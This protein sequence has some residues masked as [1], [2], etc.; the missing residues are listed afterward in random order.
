MIRRTRC[1][2]IAIA[3][4][5][6]FCFFTSAAFVAPD[7]ATA[8]TMMPAPA[9][10]QISRER[11]ATLTGFQVE[12]LIGVRAR[13]D[14]AIVVARSGKVLRVTLSN[15]ETKEDR[16]PSPLVDFALG[17]PEPLGLTQTGAVISM[18]TVIG[19]PGWSAGTF[20]SCAIDS[21]G[22]DALLSGGK[23]SFFL[24][25]N[26]SVAMPI[27]SSKFAVLWRDGF[28]WN[29]K[30][31]AGNRVWQADIT[32]VYGNRMKRMYRFSPEF[33]PTGLRVGPI[34][35]DGDLLLSFYV[36]SQREIALLGQ[37][38]RMFWRLPVH[39][40]VCPRDLAFDM[41]GRL[42][43]IERDGPTLILNRLIFALPEG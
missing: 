33:D 25:K 29:L 38:G 21:F 28:L 34:S 10:I 23:A 12:N 35:S 36:S 17:D 39:D 1:I 7:I 32:D 2:Y 6:T 43:M 8:A 14:E 18:N 11:I 27:S 13:G 24:A 26:A 42:L 3:L 9:T 19:H 22:G 37:N 31:G 41:Q 16:F 30:R 15:G 20:D 40:A 4:L 5:A